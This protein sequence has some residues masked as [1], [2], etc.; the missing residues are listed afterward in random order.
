MP[1]MVSILVSGISM[2]VLTFRSDY[3]NKWKVYGHLGISIPWTRVSTCA[4][5]C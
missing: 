2:Q 4:E 1:E 5:K 3:L